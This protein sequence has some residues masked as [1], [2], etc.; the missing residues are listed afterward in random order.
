MRNYFKRD[1]LFAK[2]DDYKDFDEK[3][4]DVERL[5]VGKTG[6]RTSTG[7]FFEHKDSYVVVMY[8]WG[9]KEFEDVLN[10]RRFTLNKPGCEEINLASFSIDEFTPL[11]EILD[12]KGIKYGYTIKRKELREIFYPEE[13]KDEVL[14]KI[15]EVSYKIDESQ[16]NESEKSDFRRNLL[17]TMDGYVEAIANNTNDTLAPSIKENALNFLS[18]IESMIPN[19]SVDDVKKESE[20]LKKTIFRDIKNRQKCLFLKCIIISP[21][22]NKLFIFNSWVSSLWIR[23]KIIISFCYIIYCI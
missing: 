20:R 13:V 9:S 2:Y 19:M 18:I 7:H 14:K 12:E 22:T 21:R 15:V 5:Y 4:L 3:E 6:Y 10:L 23:I 17:L 16:L 1:D 8:R 11:K